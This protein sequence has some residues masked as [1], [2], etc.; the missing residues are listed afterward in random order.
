M[1]DKK[2]LNIKKLVYSRQ[3]AHLYIFSICLHVYY[4]EIYCILFIIF[5]VIL[6]KVLLK[7]ARERFF[8]DALKF[9]RKCLQYT[10]TEYY[11]NAL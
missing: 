2:V 5:R 6:L 4:I 11:S 3:N 1:K 7:L 8:A 9:N 10:Q